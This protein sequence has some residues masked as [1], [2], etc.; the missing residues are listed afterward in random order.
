MLVSVSAITCLS[1]ADFREALVRLPVPFLVSSILVQ[2]VQQSG[3]LFYETQRVA[4][5]SESGNLAHGSTRSERVSRIGRVALP[6][7]R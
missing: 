5:A 4:A 1:A 2:I 7:P 6:A 3:T